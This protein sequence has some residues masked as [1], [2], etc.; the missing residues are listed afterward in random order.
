MNMRAILLAAFGFAL[1]TTGC[2]PHFT[3][4]TPKDFVV[5]DESRPYDFRATTPDGLV[6]AVREFENDKERGDAGFW[7][8]AIE[9][10]LRIDKGYALLKT[11]EIKTRSGLTGTQLRFG[12]DR[13]NEAHEYIV[14]VFVTFRGT[15]GGK[16]SSV[17]VLEA[18]GSAVLV[19]QHRA[20]IQ[21][22]ILGFDGR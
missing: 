16:R 8:R 13:E 3:V 7:V 1:G 2:G 15:I 20:Q 9:N 11:D 12:L 5:L 22:A 19:E 18:G 14:T 21:D 17:Y 4:T 10:E 6:L